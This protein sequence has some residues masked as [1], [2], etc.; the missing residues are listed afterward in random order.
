MIREF[1]NVKLSKIQLDGDGRADLHSIISTSWNR[2][3]TFFNRCG[4]TDYTGDDSSVS[5]AMINAGIDT[6]LHS[7]DRQR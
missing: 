2:G 7:V 4:A 1:F 3:E 6:D 5:Y